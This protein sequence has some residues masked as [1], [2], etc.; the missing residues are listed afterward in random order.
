MSRDVL[1][2]LDHR[3]GSL[4][5]QSHGLV[6]CACELAAASGGRA[7]ALLL[8]ASENGIE[9]SLATS[10]LHTI[11]RVLDARLDPYS[12]EAWARA[13]TAAVEKLQPG[14]LLCAHTSVGRE[15]APWVAAR[16]AAPLLSNCLTLRA[17]AGE[18]IAERLVY[19]GSWQVE[20]RVE[21][22]GPV[23]ASLA[24][25]AAPKACGA[26]PPSLEPLDIGSA[27]G[28]VETRVARESL[29]QGD[30]DVA[31]ADVV[32]GGGRGVA[33]ASDLA[34]LEAL[35]QA[36]GGV[37][38]GSRPLVDRGWLPAERLVG[39]SGSAIRPRVYVACGISGASHHL[40][41]IAG[42]GTIVAINADAD[43]PI[44]RVADVGVV[45]DLRDILPALLAEARRPA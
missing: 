11:H 40:A 12:P 17:E 31:R 34:L 25:G 38:A 45:A 32:V 27:L 14:L 3:D 30:V 2:L 10:G 26:R 44:F 16:V 37:V 8:S 24:R 39:A 29:A 33:T 23:V 4:D 6:N 35:A 43:A 13:T 42:A 20:L 18:L 36:L 7:D 28:E 15:I 9:K 22:Q 19:S 5:P 21:W 41:G 1:L